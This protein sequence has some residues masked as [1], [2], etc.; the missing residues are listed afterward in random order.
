MPARFHRFEGYCLDNQLRELRDVDGA[1]VPLTAKAFDTLGFLVEHRDRLVAKD[2][3]LAAVWAGRVVEDNNLTQAIAALRRAFGTSAADHRFIITVPGRGYRFVAEVQADAPPPP[4]KIA[5]ELRLRRI[6]GAGALL[7]ALALFAVVGWQRRSDLAAPALALPAGQPARAL[8]VLPFRAASNP[9]DALLEIGLADTLVTR[10]VRSPGLR[11]RSLAS[12]QQLAGSDPFEAGRRLGADYVVDGSAQRIGDR[13]RVNARL[14]S[15]RQGTAVWSDTFD[16]RMAQVFGLQDDIAAAVVAALSLQPT[17]VDPRTHAP[18]DGADLDATRALLRAQ[19]DLHRRKQGTIAAFQ[20]VIR[21]DP[22]CARAYAGLASAYLFMAHNDS[23]PAQTFPLAGAVA[24]QALRIDP[25]SADGHMARGRYLQ[26]YAWDWRGAEAELRRAIALNPSLADAHFG[27]AHVLTVTGRFDEALAEARQ[28]QEL[29]PLAPL[30]DALGAGFL[31]AAGKPEAARVQLEQALAQEP[32]FWIAL[33]VRGGLALDR[34]D[35]ASAITDLE[36]AAARSRRTSQVLAV[37]ASA[38]V[39]GGQRDQAQAILRELQG[40]AALGY[41]PG[42]SL[43]AVHA[44]L[45]DTDAALAELER[46]FAQ[47]DIRIGF[48]QVD[49]RWNGLRA[50][51]RF[52]ALSRRLGLRSGPATGRF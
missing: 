24:A 12:A 7:F 51:P 40:R 23:P 20:D 41:V 31:S 28:A 1:V 25:D 17:V 26:L 44:A 18:C 49:A 30:I 36:R 3:L 9:R 35:N 27:L 46:A 13:V 39:A 45:G 10:L 48:L 33:L 11:V 34:G 47:H 38:Y 8:A 15:V 50:Q 19:Y 5:S 6:A 32:D 43:A 37:L 4:V 21:L 22:S 2:E 52:Q 14:L 29:D 16:A 42:T